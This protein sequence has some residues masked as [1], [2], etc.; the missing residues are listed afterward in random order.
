MIETL[1]K[2]AMGMRS[3]LRQRPMAQGQI[4]MAGV[5][6]A[7][8]IAPWIAIIALTSRSL[9]DALSDG[10]AAVLK[11]RVFWLF[12]L[13]IGPLMAFV[14]AHPAPADDLLRDMRSWR[15]GFDYRSMF[16][17][18]PGVQSGD[19]YLGFD[20]A[21]GWVDRAVS[22][23]GFPNWT[24][25]P[26]VGTNM[27]LW[28]VG[29]VAVLRKARKPCNDLQMALFIGIVLA[30]WLTPTFTERILSGRPEAFFAL[31]ALCALS[32]ET[33]AQAI[34]WSIF[35]IALSSW[36]W[37]FWIYVPAAV[38]LFPARGWSLRAFVYRSA[39]ATVILVC[40][41]SFWW[42]ASKGEY[43]QWFFHL[44]E[45]MRNRV[46]PVAE[47]AGLGLAMITPLIVLIVGGAILA[48]R[49][50]GPWL[51][52]N[53]RYAPLVLVALCAWFALPNMVRYI[54]SVAS[55]G[56]A[57]V[58]IVIADKS[59]D[60][61]VPKR[62]MGVIAFACVTWLIW[63]GITMGTAQKP[64][65]NLTL[66]DAR[67][68]DR[69]LTFFSPSTYDAVYENTQIKVAPAFELGFSDRDVQ[70]ASVNLMRG[71]VDCNWLRSHD[72]RWVVAPAHAEIDA[73]DWGLCLDLYRLDKGVS[74]WKLRLPSGAERRQ[75]TVRQ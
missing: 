15:V 27:L 73:K 23:A 64:L 24:W 33:L 65:Q 51:W 3:A 70:M 35:G 11:E 10:F 72:V 75:M 66:N 62:W 57:A 45:A 49:Q 59:R 67:P 21:I 44:H 20:W 8:V 1:K 69:V 25:V 7:A 58:W 46:I 42:V 61:E 26:V 37:F 39:A 74:I 60:V 28:G 18:S 34:I 56:L 12:V 31:W 22:N 9:R 55:L 16:W 6:V 68:G 17:G 14:A 71:K 38:L 30:T 48:P 47:N 54:D 52:S 19:Y 5:A 36:Y 50:S 43:V 41:F 2:L 4:G 40:G 63:G 29:L 53:E 13:S 32:V